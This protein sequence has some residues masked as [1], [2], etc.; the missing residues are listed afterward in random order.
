MN[1]IT[2]LVMGVLLFVVVGYA[3]IFSAIDH[4][5]DELC[6]RINNLEDEI[7][8]QD[9]NDNLEEGDD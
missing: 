4:Q 9:D 3:I 5:I 6:E 7:Y 1:F 8:E 2:G